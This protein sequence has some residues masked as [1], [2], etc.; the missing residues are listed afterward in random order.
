MSNQLKRSSQARSSQDSAQRRLRRLS[1]RPRVEKTPEEDD[2]TTVKVPVST[3]HYVKRR[4][5]FLVA[6]QPARQEKQLQNKARQSLPATREQPGNNSRLLVP[7]PGQGERVEI[8]RLPVSE[9]QDDMSLLDT[10][11]LLAPDLDTTQVLDTPDD[12]P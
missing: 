1:F 8:I 7:K 5:E 11:T 2:Q 10:M 12:D 3:L 6:P 4:R 9:S